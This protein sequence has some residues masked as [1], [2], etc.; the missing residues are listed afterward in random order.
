MTSPAT[1]P[2]LA[3]NMDNSTPDY[4]QEFREKFPYSAIE[5][6]GEKATRNIF[7]EVESFLTTLVS[8]AEAR[9]W[10]R[11]VQV[12]ST[13]TKNSASRYQL[14]FQDGEARGRNQAVDYLVSTVTY[15]GHIGADNTARVNMDDMTKA[16]E[17]A[18]NAKPI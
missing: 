12:E 9:G 7:A 3:L 13:R 6:D 11:G 5:H 1:T 18:R 8:E 17:S 16:L 2:C 14:G 10:K 4:I 15:H